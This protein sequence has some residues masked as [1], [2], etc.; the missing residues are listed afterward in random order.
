MAADYG[1]LEARVTEL[2]HQ[3]RHVLPAKMDAMNFGISVLH[4]DLRALREETHDALGR[5]ETALG[6]Q[7]TALRRQETALGRQETA[8]RRQETALRRQETAL[9]R[10][11]IRLDR[12]GELLA[13]ILRRLPPGAPAP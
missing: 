7:E 3:M 4:D 6:R 1:A 8:L 12:H 10:Q 2:E 13:E 5:Q 11:E 9:G